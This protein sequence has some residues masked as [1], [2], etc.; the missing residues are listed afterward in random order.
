MYADDAIDE[1]TCCRL[2]IKFHDRTKSYKNHSRSRRSSVD[3]DEDLD[4]TTTN[5][6]HPAV[7]KLAET[8][9]ERS[10]TVERW[11]HA[12]GFI[13]KLDQWVTHQ[14]TLRQ[15]DERISICVS[16]LSCFSKEPLNQIVA[17]DEKWIPYRNVK[18]DRVSML[19]SVCQRSKQPKNILDNIW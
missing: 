1:T 6:S 3:S 18:E 8:I 9:S 15:R 19:Q 12:L 10:K 16:L 5:S 17:D 13:I 2:F 4:T 7:A 14:L 11:M